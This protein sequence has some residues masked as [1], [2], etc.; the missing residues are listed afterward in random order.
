MPLVTAAL[1]IKRSEPTRICTPVGHR[2]AVISGMPVWTACDPMLYLGRHP[3]A[4]IRSSS[5]TLAGTASAR[6]EVRY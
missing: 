1:A 4:R 2:N 3:R 5:S 6:I